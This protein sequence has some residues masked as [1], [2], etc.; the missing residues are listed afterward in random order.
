R[1]FL[2]DE[3]EQLCGWR[4]VKTGEEKI[5]RK[6][7]RYLQKAFSGIQII[8]PEIFPLIKQHGKFSMVD[9]YLDLAKN[10]SMLGFEHNPEKLVDAGK[11]E[12]LL[13]AEEL[14]LEYGVFTEGGRWVI[15][16]INHFLLKQ[17]LEKAISKT[18]GFF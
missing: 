2:F 18:D 5:S 9:V 3:K 17:T 8:S 4:N 15:D 7:T 11:P 12:S 16:R 14:F 1:Y 10:Y 13:K 6:S